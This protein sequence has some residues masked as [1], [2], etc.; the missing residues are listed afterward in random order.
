[1]CD[2][3]CPDEGLRFA[4]LR[5]SGHFLAMATPDLAPRVR[6]YNFS[7][8]VDMGRS[9]MEGIA[10]NGRMNQSAHPRTG[11]VELC[12]LQKK[13]EKRQNG[14]TMGGHNLYVRVRV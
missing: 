11:R 4:G 7:T 14:A 10:T 8:R 12:C 5:A 9:D 3:N 1:M 6:G 2:R 13:P